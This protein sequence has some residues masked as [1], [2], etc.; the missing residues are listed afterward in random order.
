M[1]ATNYSLYAMDLNADGKSGTILGKSPLGDVVIDFHLS[2]DG[3]SGT[4][5]GKSPLGDAVIG[6]HL[7]ADGKSGT[8]SGKLPRSDVAIGFKL[9]ADGKS[10]TVSGKLP[11]GDVVIG[12]DYTEAPAELTLTILEKPMF[13]PVP[14]LWADFS[15]ALRWATEG[16]GLGPEG[17]TLAHERS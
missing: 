15:Y 10:G 13:V 7:S 5:S 8:V 6:F 17:K 3:K 11:R 1:R 12:F 4:V 14:L 16:L 2:A 9:S